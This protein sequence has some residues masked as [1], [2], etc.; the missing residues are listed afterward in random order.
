MPK[1]EWNAERGSHIIR[2]RATNAKGQTQTEE[3]AE[4]APDGAT[5]WHTVNVNV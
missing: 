5:G 2:V 4:V 3:R 1:L